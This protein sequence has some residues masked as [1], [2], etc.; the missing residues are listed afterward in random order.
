[1]EL[2]IGAAV[3]L[4]VQGL[5]QKATSQ[6]QTLGILLVLSIATAGLYCTLIAVGYWETIANILVTAGAFYA[7][8]LQRFESKAE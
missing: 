2:L 7:F 5:K 6:W 1:M 4:I 8:V 3:S